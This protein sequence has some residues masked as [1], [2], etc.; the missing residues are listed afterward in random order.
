MKRLTQK[1]N[2]DPESELH[3]IQFLDFQNYIDIISSKSN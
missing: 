3:K 1:R 2:E